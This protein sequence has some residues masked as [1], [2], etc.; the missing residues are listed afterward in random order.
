MIGQSYE[1]YRDLLGAPSYYHKTNETSIWEICQSCFKKQYIMSATACPN[2]EDYKMMEQSGII[3]FQ[4]YSIINLAVA[5]D[6]YG[7]PTKLIQLRNPWGRFEWNG[8]W[9]DE[10]DQWTEEA[11]RIVQYE[12]RDD[13]VFW[14]PFLAFQQFFVSIHICKY[15]AGYVF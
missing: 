2:L 11:K 10:S 6:K 3:A 13:G 1:V 12:E 14:M 7:V 9:S 4:S 8:E 5:P 15:V